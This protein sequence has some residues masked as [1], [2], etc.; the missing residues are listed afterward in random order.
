VK[1]IALALLLTLFSLGVVG[2]AMDNDERIRETHK[3]K[4]AGLKAHGWVDAF[5]GV[6]IVCLPDEEK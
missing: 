6:H 1:N 5:N 4:A 3:C 2:C